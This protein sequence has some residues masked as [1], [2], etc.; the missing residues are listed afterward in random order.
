MTHLL[1][2]DYAE[3]PKSD[4]VLVTI[5][6]EYPS[7]ASCVEMSRQWSHKSII[8]EDVDTFIWTDHNTNSEP[9]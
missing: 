4:Y 7:L 5:C 9:R 2:R 3:I 6:N 1:N 8:K